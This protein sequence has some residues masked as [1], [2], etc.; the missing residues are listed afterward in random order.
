[1]ALLTS[2]FIDVKLPQFVEDAVPESL[3]LVHPLRAI[4]FVYG[5]ALLPQQLKVVLQHLHFRNQTGY[6]RKYY[7][8]FVFVCNLLIGYFVLG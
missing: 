2:G 4:G 8:V 5:L 7:Y 1:M 6:V 3:L